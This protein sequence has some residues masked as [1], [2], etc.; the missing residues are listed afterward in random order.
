M[1]NKLLVI[2]FTVLVGSCKRDTSYY[3]IPII[4]KVLTINTP[5]F[6]DYAYVC[7]DTNKSHTIEDYVD[8][9]ILRGET[10]DVSL[11]LNK[12]KIIKL[13][14]ISYTRV[15]PIG[16]IPSNEALN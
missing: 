7:V 9:K 8:F 11:I 13:L 16:I 6:N 4:D 10:T 5:A 2:I 15:C 12:F 3:E 1:K 14:L